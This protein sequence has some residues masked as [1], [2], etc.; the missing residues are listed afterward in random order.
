MSSVVTVSSVFFFKQ[1]TA[2]EMRISD[3][4]SDVCSSDLIHAG[5][6]YRQPTTANGWPSYFVEDYVAQSAAFQN[7]LISLTAEG[8]LAKHPSL[9]V[10]LIVSGFTWLPA[11]TWRSEA[12]STGIR[13]ETP[14]VARPASGIV[15]EPLAFTHHPHP[16][17]PH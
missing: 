7:Q 9:K 2:Y 14:W 10:A 1:K 11:W 13:R 6:G 15:A 16:T 3:W 12:T 17:P 8:V 4:S 5:S